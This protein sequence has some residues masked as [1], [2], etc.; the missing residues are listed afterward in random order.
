LESFE[1]WQFCIKLAVAGWCGVRLAH[2]TLRYHEQTGQ[3]RREGYQRGQELIERI[4]GPYRARLAG[5]EPLMGCNC[6]DVPARQKAQRFV[7]T[8]PQV[9]AGVVVN[10]DGVVRMEFI[11]NNT[12]SRSFSIDPL[13]N[14]PFTK[15]YRGA[16]NAHYR[17]ANAAPE[18]VA[19]LETLGLW[20]RVA[21]VVVPPVV[22]TLGQVAMPA[23]AVPE[24]PAPLAPLAPVQAEPVK[25]PRL[26][27][28]LR[29]QRS[30]A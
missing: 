25:G 30:G 14:R 12:G 24:P 18:D 23:P 9:A 28:G 19:G 26:P 7:A 5:K 1:D 21:V 27:A 3:R 20:R 4:V 6:G 13:T 10:A 22:S 11:G 29:R 16:N 8:W 17:Y 15:V 2:P